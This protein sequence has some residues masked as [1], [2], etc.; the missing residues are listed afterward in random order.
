MVAAFAMKLRT[1]AKV[2]GT[3][4]SGGQ[5]ASQLGVAPWQVDRAR[6]DLQGWNEEG[7]G[8]AILTV[9][10]TDA[11][12]KGAQRDPIYALETLVRVIA[13]RGLSS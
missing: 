8:R 7:L 3:R 1:M 9:A 2:G 10:E 5:V 4:G 13:T 11:A 12:V 6:R